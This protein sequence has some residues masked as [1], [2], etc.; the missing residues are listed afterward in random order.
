MVKGHVITSARTDPFSNLATD[1]VLLRAVD[2]GELGPVLRFWRDRACVVVGKSQSIDDEVNLQFCKERHISIA[3]RITGG[4][5]VYH[6]EGVLNMTFVVPRSLLPPALDVT[7]LNLFFTTLVAGALIASKCAGIAVEGNTT[8]L[9]GGKKISGGAAY[10]KARG[11][12]HHAT[13]LVESNLDWLESSLIASAATPVTRSGSRFMETGNVHG[14]VVGTFER[15]LVDKLSTGINVEFTYH[16]V[17]GNLDDRI[18]ALSMN[19]YTSEWWIY[20]K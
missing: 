8:I 2:L 13:L 12:L 3:R 15:E 20:G 16:E 10:H 4:G 14:L 1:E 9:Q 19:K 11:I 7:G 6:D 5:A 17:P 18:E